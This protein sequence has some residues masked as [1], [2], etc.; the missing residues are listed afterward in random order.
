MKVGQKIYLKPIGNN[1]RYGNQEVRECTIS[2]I[3]RKYFELEEKGY[4]R[5]FIE[6]MAQDCGQYI[7]GYQAYLSIQDI[8]DE[9]E[10]KKLYS[11]I[12]KAFSGFSTSLSLS[13]LKEIS[14]IIN[15][16]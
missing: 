3:G 2:K 14:R 6:S 1:A 15:H 8:E 13:E 7:S 10:A 9:E 4:G 16:E 5:F 12:K 11:E